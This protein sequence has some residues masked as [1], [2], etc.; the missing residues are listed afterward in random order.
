MNLVQKSVN[1]FYIKGN[2][3]S[4]STVCQNFRD[5]CNE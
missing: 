2:T 3:L 1:D 5:K 4:L